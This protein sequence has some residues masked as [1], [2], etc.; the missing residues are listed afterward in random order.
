MTGQYSCGTCKIEVKN[1]D[2]L[3]MILCEKWNHV[4]CV[5]ISSTEYEKLKFSTLR[6]Y[7]PIFA[8]EIPFSS[9]SNKG[10]NIY[11]ETLLILVLKLCLPRKLI[12]I[13]KRS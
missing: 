1:E 2:E 7:C 9:L 6:W 8:K 13:Q 12:N 3:S 5:D 10:S 11:P 4:F